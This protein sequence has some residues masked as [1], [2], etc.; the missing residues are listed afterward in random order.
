MRIMFIGDLHLGKKPPHSTKESAHRGRI[1]THLTAS[2]LAHYEGIDLVVQLGDVFDRFTVTDDDFV[3]ALSLTSM[4]DYVLRGNHDYAH[5]TLYNS[6]LQNLAGPTTA[7]IVSLPCSKQIAD[8]VWLHFVPYMPTQKEFLSAIDQL[9]PVTG[10][11]NILC[12]H[13]NMY[14][15]GFNVAEVEN[16]LTATKANELVAAFD[17][18]ISGHEHN[19]AIKNGVHMV[20]SVLPFS[21]G[22]MTDKFGEVYD[23]DTKEYHRIRTWKKTEGHAQV[24]ADMFL[25]A[26]QSSHPYQF[27]ELT[28]EVLPEQVLPI[29]KKMRKMF[30]ESKVVSIKNS[31]KVKK[32]AISDKGYEDTL[33]WQTFVVDQLNPEQAKLFQELMQ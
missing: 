27:L 12:L 11:T 31:L 13:T 22:D 24:P 1:T 6:A 21:F 5:N 14:A 20:G 30:E 4:C 8:T 10:C 29:A 28:G 23:T 19:A 33:S 7:F 26:F 17:F 16:N 3:E 18:V 15:E 9:E 32:A 2:G 25:E